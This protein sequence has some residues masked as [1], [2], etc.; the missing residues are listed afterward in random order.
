MTLHEYQIEAARTCPDLEDKDNIL[1]MNI[2]ILTELGELAD[3]FKK[4]Y[5]Y[6]KELDLVHIGEEI[7]DMFWYRAN[8]DR[9]KG[10]TYNPNYHIGVLD[11]NSPLITSIEGI[12]NSL[13]EFYDRNFFATLFGIANFYSL[14]IETLLNNNI[15]KLRIRYPEKFDTEKAL[16]RRLELERK[17]LEK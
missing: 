6:G 4:H 8:L 2:G 3:L 15:A 12:M 13:V 10:Y 1:H 7:A 11:D 17:E 5:A 9:I 16:N 14:N